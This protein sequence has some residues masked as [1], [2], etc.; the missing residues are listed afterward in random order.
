MKIRPIVLTTLE[1]GV[2]QCLLI[3]ITMLRIITDV[4]E[5]GENMDFNVND[6]TI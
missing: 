5:G 2:L 6:S 4:A 1:L 3:A